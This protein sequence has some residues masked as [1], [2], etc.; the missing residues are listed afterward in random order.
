[1]KQ[2]DNNTQVLHFDLYGRREDKYDFLHNNSISTIDWNELSP[3][4]PYNFFVPKDFDNA[5]E[6]ENG[7]KVDEMFTKYSSGIESQKDNIAVQISKK[8][9]NQIIED[10]TNLS[11]MDLANKYKLKDARD[12]KISTSKI[13]VIKNGKEKISRILY[14][15]FDIRFSYLSGT[16]K[17]L[18]A[19]PRYEISKNLLKQNIALLTCS[20]QTSFDFQHCF[21]SK[22][23]TERCTVSLQTGEVGYVFPLYLYPESSGQ[24]SNEQA[25]TPVPPEEGNKTKGNSNLEGNMT[26]DRTPNLNMEIV[27]KI[28]EKLGLKFIPEKF[29]SFGGVSEG[30]GGG[31]SFPASEVQGGGYSLKGSSELS[32][33]KPTTPAPPEEGNKP[34]EFSGKNNVSRNTLNYMNLPYNPKLKERARELRKSGNLSEVLF[35]NQVKNKQFKGYDF[36]RQKIIGNYIVDFYCTNC[37]VVIEID[38]SSHDDMQE[39]DASRDAFL[40]GLGLCVIHI[41]DSDVKNNLS[42]VMDMLSNHPALMVAEIEQPSRLDESVSEQPP[43]YERAVNE[44][45]PPRPSDTP[46]MEGNFAPIDILDYIYAVLHSPTYR[47]KYKE[48]LKIDFPRV[49]YPKDKDTFW[50]LVKSGGELRQIHL[51]ESSVTE[52]YITQY[53]VDG[54]NEVTKPR[55]EKATTPA[56]PEEGN[57]TM[58]NMQLTNS[59]P[60]EGCPKDGVVAVHILSQHNAVVGKVFIND[61]QYFANV[62]EVAWN[63]YIGGYQPAQKWL[64]D[65]KGR[66]LEFDDILHYQKII[67]ALTETNR[68]MK[69]IDEIEIELKTFSIL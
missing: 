46:P 37:N 7:F 3:V 54:N 43:R 48:F 66:K 10:F 35:W 13:D 28:S 40:E 4:E 59:P 23:P 24:Q 30:R 57:K 61:S 9:I 69:E 26:M 49:P 36:D 60:L 2:P 51:L 62:P 52:N 21:I 42:G 29:P 68:I 8:E 41:Y 65:R 64:K 6:Y 22:Y 25:T 67:V 53:P 44:Q 56:P 19:Y 63:F 15:P 39:Y 12:W 50:K 45:P 47:E 38:G 20:R 16:S 14:R 55:F 27:N 34:E 5:N 58:E 32:E 33:L 17:G 1:M 18:V 31:C 11:E